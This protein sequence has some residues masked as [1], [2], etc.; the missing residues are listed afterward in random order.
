MLLSLHFASNIYIEGLPCMHTK[1]THAYNYKCVRIFSH[2]QFG[3]IYVVVFCDTVFNILHWRIRD[4]H[5]WT[6]P[7]QR[8]TNS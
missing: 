3:L 1:M 4:H 8:D 7:V 2:T 5:V 6:G